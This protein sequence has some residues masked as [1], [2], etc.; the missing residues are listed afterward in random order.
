MFHDR[1]RA[2]NALPL[3][4]WE[5]PKAR[6]VLDVFEMAGSDTLRRARTIM[7]LNSIA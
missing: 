2:Q 3:P 4:L 6:G 5:S 7:L 1:L